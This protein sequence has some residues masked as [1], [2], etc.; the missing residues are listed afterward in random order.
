[1]LLTIVK[2]P[3]A[4]VRAIYNPLTHRYTEVTSGYPVICLG[5]EQGKKGIS[6]S[7]DFKLSS[8]F[9]DDAIICYV[10][11]YGD[12]QGID[13][14]TL[15]K[16]LK[17][18]S[19]WLN[20]AHVQPVRVAFSYSSMY[21]GWKAPPDRTPRWWSKSEGHLLRLK[22]RLNETGFVDVD[23]APDFKR[24]LTVMFWAEQS[25]SR[26]FLF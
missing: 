18:A 25:Q 24:E 15:K 23:F 5:K 20:L 10:R 26:A 12:E 11:E 4:Y 22:K 2:A 7:I 14:E 1:M 3:F 6:Y 19:S 21:L 17:I 13:Q 16:A 9:Y 8:G